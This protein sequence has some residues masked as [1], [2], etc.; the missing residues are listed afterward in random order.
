MEINRNNYER[1]FLDFVEGALSAEEEDIVRRFLRF[2][3]DLEDE[4]D[5]FASIVLPPDE[6]HYPYRE[7]LKKETGGKTEIKRQDRELRAIAYLEKD[8][9]PE[10]AA[11]FELELTENRELARQVELL[12][13]TFLSPAA[14][15]YPHSKSL[16]QRKIV[17]LTSLRTILSLATAASVA[18]FLILR[19][20]RPGDGNQMAM[21]EE[22]VEVVAPASEPSAPQ[23][24]SSL[25]TEVLGQQPEP[26]QVQTTNPAAVERRRQQ[27]TSPTIKVIRD[28][29]APVPTSTITRDPSAVETGRESQRLAGITLK[30]ADFRV[31]EA[32]QQQIEWI[33]TGL[34]EINAG[35]LSVGQLARYQINR[36]NEIAEQD[37]QLLFSLATLGITEINKRAGTSMSLLA[38]TN[39]EGAINGL[40]FRSRLLSVRTPVNREEN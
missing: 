28:T 26:R 31:A 18:L 38:S 14:I 17:K 24:E 22:P 37:E 20:D 7:L 19:I 4:L 39:N 8:L 11:S 27:S 6:V 29:N 1:Y 5:E 36:F 25:R 23:Q 9:T 32:P 13:K 3:P 33:E 30:K 34:P 2:N 35:S 12:R 16:K 21:V 10:Q 40:E 15:T